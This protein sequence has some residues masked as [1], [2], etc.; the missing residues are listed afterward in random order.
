MTKVPDIPGDPEATTWEALEDE[1]LD[2]DV[3]EEHLW[4]EVK[5]AQAARRDVR[6]GS[7]GRDWLALPDTDSP[8]DAA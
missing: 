6:H 3:P 1:L 7:K 4:P 8:Q 2:V 5:A